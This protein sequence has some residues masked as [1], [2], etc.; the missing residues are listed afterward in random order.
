MFRLWTSPASE[1]A[2]TLS[3]EFGLTVKSRCEYYCLGKRKTP[4]SESDP[5]VSLKWQLIGCPLVKKLQLD[6]IIENKRQKRQTTKKNCTFISNMPIW[7]VFSVKKGSVQGMKLVMNKLNLN[8]VPTFPVIYNIWFLSFLRFY[9]IQYAH[10]MQMEN[11]TTA[12]WD[13]QPWN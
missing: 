3:V 9:Q 11:T 6:Q 5:Y 7:T 10:T 13:N 4:F 12:F 2:P 1:E 8:Q